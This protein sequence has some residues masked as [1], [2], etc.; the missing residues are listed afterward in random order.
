MEN[1]IEETTS[2][3]KRLL[4][5]ATPIIVQHLITVGLNLVDNIMVGRLGALPLAAV[6][7]ANQVYSIYEMVL[8]GLFSGAAVPL[9]QYYG[10]RDYKNIKRIVGMD[11]TM[12]LSLAILTLVM[13]Q[14]FAP[15]IISLFA[16][17]QEV[18][19]LGTQYIRIASF[20]YLTVAVSFVISYNSR[21]V[22]IV[23]VPTIINICSILT[24]T[25][26]N[27]ILI[28]G[29][30]GMPALGVRG[31]AIATLIARIIELA[32]LVIYLCVDKE[33]PFHGK[34]S[35]FKGFSRDLFRRV[36]RTAMPV[37]ISEG[38]W[39]L[40]VT[41]TFAAYGKISAEALAVMQVSNVLCVFCQ[42]ASFGL[43]N[44][45]AALTGEML[46]QKQT[47]LA[48]ENTKKY[49]KV[50]WILTGIM[51]VMILALR[52]PIALIYHFDEETTTMLMLALGVFAFTMIPRMIAYAVQCGILRAGGDTLFCMVVELSCNLGIEVILA[53]VSVL[54]FHLPLH[55]CIAVAAAGNLIKAIIEYRRYLSK[56]WIN[57][58]I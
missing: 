50:Q 47:E 13:A 14:L 26:L 57:V 39:S 34:L 17:E 42:C 45:S 6:G 49:M 35:E 56:K 48:Y 40:G 54:V 16:K 44:A 53:Y 9:A 3:Y 32:A 29:N 27:Y 37:V 15:Q 2:Y 31:A 25:L 33:H 46:G 21:S 38:G 19:R 23:K 24:N 4:L 51:T 36:M 22:Q 28:Y 41:L 10:A 58:I 11:I 5:L 55:L 20:T 52:G 1:R 7:S 8:F 43:G 12:G 18:V 30:F